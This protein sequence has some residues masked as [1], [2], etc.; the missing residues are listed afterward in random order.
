MCKWFCVFEDIHEFHKISVKTSDSGGRLTKWSE[1][2]VRDI[3]VT[4]M[5]Q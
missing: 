4:H 1:C 3:Q 2:S 5:G